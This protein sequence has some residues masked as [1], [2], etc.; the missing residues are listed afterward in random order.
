MAPALRA[1]PNKEQGGGAPAER[2]YAKLGGACETWRRE[3]KEGDAQGSSGLL[4][5]ESVDTAKVLIER[6]REEKNIR[7]FF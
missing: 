4:S 5:R 1:E 2:S 3:E 6:T 7:Q